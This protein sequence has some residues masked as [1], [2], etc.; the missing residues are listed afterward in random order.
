M[1]FVL[2]W[3]NWSP[4]TCASPKMTSSAVSMPPCPRPFCGASGRSSHRSTSR[5]I[6]T[7][8]CRVRRSVG[9]SGRSFQ[10]WP[11]S[12]VLWVALPNLGP[13]RSALDLLPYDPKS[14]RGALGLDSVN[15]DRVDADNFSSDY[16]LALQRWGHRQNIACLRENPLRSL[17][18]WD[19]IEQFVYQEGDWFDL[20]YDA[21]VF[22]WARRKA[23]KFRRNIPE[24][25]SL[26]A[27]RC[28]HLHDPNEWRSSRSGQF[29]TFNE[30]EY[31]PSLVFTLA[32]C[33]TAR[34]GYGILAIPRLPPI[35]TSGDIRPLLHF[36]PSELR[37]DLMT[38]MGFHLAFRL[39]WKTPSMS[40]HA[41]L[42]LMS[43][44]I[45]HI[46]RTRTCTLAL[47][48]FHTVGH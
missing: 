35:A 36:E 25:A 48:T 28:G 24:L 43:F 38:V 41:W 7:W 9:L 10:E 34:Q 2:F 31:T 6:R 19:P 12:L 40:Q 11:L 33:C 14:F 17:H 26:P 22:G 47:A 46:S 15:Q 4:L 42:Q 18:W 39:P 8:T 20:D 3:M 30:A 27:V 21:C 23:Q 45:V 29:S 44:R 13:G 37:E 16:L 1:T 5:L 32:V